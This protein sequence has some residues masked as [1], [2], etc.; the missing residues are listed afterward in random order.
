MEEKCGQSN[1]SLRNISCDAWGIVSSVD[2]FWLH[3][4]CHSALGQQV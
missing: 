1:V 3:D 2:A 4:L